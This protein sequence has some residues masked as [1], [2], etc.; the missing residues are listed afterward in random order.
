MNSTAFDKI[1]RACE[2]LST[3]YALYLDMA[4]F[5]ECAGLFGEHGVL[6]VAGRL[7]GERAIA[8]AMHN[9]R[10]ANLRSR[11]VLTNIFIEP[12]DEMRARGTTYLTLYRHVGDESFSDAPIEP[13]AP[14]AVGHYSDEFALTQD[15]WRFA[16]RELHLA[17]RNPEF[18]K[19]A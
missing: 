9:A 6:A 15:G 2:R 8:R 5:D 17:F 16:H 11:H 7:E 3:A 18:F 14:A 12:V 10:P 4:R 13:F 19:P 1:C